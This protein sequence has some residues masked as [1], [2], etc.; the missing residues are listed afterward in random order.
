MDEKEF[1]KRRVIMK[2]GLDPM[3][4]VTH[5]H[6]GRFLMECLVFFWERHSVIPVNW[7]WRL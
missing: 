1:I 2:D 7:M 4:P 3:I 6:V 5:P